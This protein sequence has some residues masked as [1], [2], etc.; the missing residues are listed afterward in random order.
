MDADAN[1]ID[2]KASRETSLFWKVYFLDEGVVLNYEPSLCLF[3]LDFFAGKKTNLRSLGWCK[4][5]SH[6]EV[7]RDP[8]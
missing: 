2:E 8:I 4:K 5:R 6:I 7:C 3:R 1:G